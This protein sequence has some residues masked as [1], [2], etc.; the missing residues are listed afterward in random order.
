MGFGGVDAG[1]VHGGWQRFGLFGHL[2]GKEIAECDELLFDVVGDNWSACCYIGDA[3][4]D[5]DVSERWVLSN[6]AFSEGT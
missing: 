1:C 4:G 6:I 2:F 5:I 3:S